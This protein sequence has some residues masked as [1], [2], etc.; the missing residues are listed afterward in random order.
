MKHSP[1]LLRFRVELL[2]PR[3]TKT[4]AGNTKAEYSSYGTRYAGITR[5]T[6]ND[7]TALDRDTATR[8]IIWVVRYDANI[9]PSWVVRY[10]SQDYYIDSAVDPDNGA[11][12]YLE[13]TA[14]A[15][16]DVALVN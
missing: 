11:K 10:D 3:N 16:E 5:A 4:T 2:R 6:G 1:S 7:Q 15:V 13:L 14:V 8:T 9:K 12:R